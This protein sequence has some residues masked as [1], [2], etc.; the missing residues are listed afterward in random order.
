M[1]FLALGTLQQNVHCSESAPL[2]INSDSPAYLASPLSP[3]LFN[4]WYS[5]QSKK[6]SKNKKDMWY[7][8]LYSLYFKGFKKFCSAFSVHLTA[9]KYMKTCLH[10]VVFKFNGVFFGKPGKCGTPAF[11]QPVKVFSYMLRQLQSHWKQ[12]C[13]KNHSI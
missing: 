9:H 12:Q 2:K 11:K 4:M 10:V 8:C 5:E 7:A 1:G 3:F 6:K 13:T